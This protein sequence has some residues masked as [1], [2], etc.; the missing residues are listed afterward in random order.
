[1][2]VKELIDRL[3]NYPPDLDVIIQIG[4]VR[5][6]AESSVRPGFCTHDEIALIEN[7]WDEDE[8]DWCKKEP[9]PGDN[10]LVI[11]D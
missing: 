10:C 5:K 4:H 9:Y 2:T 3:A 6:L 7:C 8:W 11:G 1:M